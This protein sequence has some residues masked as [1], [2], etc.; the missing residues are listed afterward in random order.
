MMA[1]DNITEVEARQVVQKNELVIA[2]FAKEI[3]AKVATEIE[4]HLDPDA[5]T[6]TKEENAADSVLQPQAKENWTP[7]RI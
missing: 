6:E 5:E 1:V 7:R 3:W 2:P 4:Y